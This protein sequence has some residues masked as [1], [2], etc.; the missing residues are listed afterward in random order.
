MQQFRVRT[1]SFKLGHPHVKPSQHLRETVCMNT[2]ELLP[3]DETVIMARAD[4]KLAI[5]VYPI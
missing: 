4:M 2:P 3:N 5:Y 1:T